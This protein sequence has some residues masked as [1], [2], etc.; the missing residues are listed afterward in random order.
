MRVLDYWV[1]IMFLPP[2]FFILPAS[3][4]IKLPCIQHTSSA[5]SPGVVGLSQM[6]WSVPVESEMAGGTSFPSLKLLKDI[7]LVT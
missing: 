5:R 4:P 1:A 2:C 7:R 3:H 6:T